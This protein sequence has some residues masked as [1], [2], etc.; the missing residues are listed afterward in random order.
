MPALKS[1]YLREQGERTNFTI[2]AASI[3]YH[4]KST[5][6]ESDSL[7]G[8]MSIKSFGITDAISLSIAR[9]RGPPSH[10]F[11]KVATLMLS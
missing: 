9:R 7:F 5:P 8:K 10:H 2:E 4:A 6:L 11:V 3:E 1:I